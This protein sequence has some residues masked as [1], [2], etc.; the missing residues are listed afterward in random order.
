MN[1][2]VLTVVM[3]L[4]G[5]VMQ[6]LLLWVVMLWVILMRQAGSLLCL[7]CA[8]EEAIVFSNF[9]RA[10]ANKSWKSLKYFQDGS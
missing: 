6:A 3:F 1:S 4:L 5:K 2:L 7:A 8:T 9:D 10:P